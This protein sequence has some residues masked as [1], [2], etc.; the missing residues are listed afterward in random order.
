[1]KVVVLFVLLQARVLLGKGPLR[2]ECQSSAKFDQIDVGRLW[3]CKINVFVYK[4]AVCLVKAV[5]TLSH[6]KRVLNLLNTVTPS[7]IILREGV[8]EGLS[9][10]LRVKQSILSCLKNV[11][12]VRRWKCYTQTVAYSRYR[13]HILTKLVSLCPFIQE[14]LDLTASSSSRRIFKLSKRSGSEGN[15]EQKQKQDGALLNCD[16]FQK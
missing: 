12:F 5:G 8:P 3:L 7:P 13:M 1:M 14:A 2:K 11:N 6:G 15:F 10:K 16:E 4:N 9:F